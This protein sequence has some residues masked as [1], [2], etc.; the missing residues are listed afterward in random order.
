MSLYLINVY[1]INQAY[2]KRYN[3][4]SIGALRKFPYPYRAAI[5]ISSDIDNTGTLEEFLEIQKFLNTKNQTS[6]G[7]GV[8]LEIGNSFFFYEPPNGA[9]SYFLGGPEVAKTIIDFIQAGYI[10][11]IHSYGKKHDFTRKDAILA[12]QEL[13]KINSTIDVWIDHTLSDDNLGDDVTFG[14]GDHPDSAAYHAD[15]TL[16]YGIKFVWL[17]RVTMIVGQTA[18]LSMATFTN[19]FDAAHPFYSLVNVTKEF[20]KNFLAY[21]GSKKYALH[22]ENDLVKITT[23]DDG[24]KVYEF[25]R[26]DNNWQ[27]VGVGANSKGLAYALSKKTLN[28]LKETA[29]YM[30]IYTHLGQ[31]ADCPQ[32]ICRETQDALR[33]LAAEFESGALYVTSTSK[34]L[35]YYINHRYLNWTYESKGDETII[36][37]HNVQD[38]LFGTFV[39]TEED[40]QG[41][42]FYVPEK[43]KTRVFIGGKEVEDIQHNPPDYAGRESVT[44]PLTFLKYP[45]LSLHNSRKSYRLG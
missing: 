44:I 34:L 15:L 28:R 40:L 17:G 27:G 10:D 11:T 13:H 5:S 39:P 18:P 2:H 19:I 24:Q 45:K 38:P 8:G 22:K 23:L 9:I 42:T 31:N 4:D 21:W 41:I 43:R 25:M 3:T 36:H 32:Y 33:N 30:I 16:D 7:A 20:A 12:L 35:N 14:L 26:F 29:G 6:M 37:I 1:T